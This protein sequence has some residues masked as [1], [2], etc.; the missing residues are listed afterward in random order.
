MRSRNSVKLFFGGIYAKASAQMFFPAG[1]SAV[2]GVGIGGGYEFHLASLLGIF[3][4]LNVDPLFKSEG[5]IVP[6]EVR[7]GV[8]LIF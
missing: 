1:S 8:T 5:T 6:V 4:E 2:F 7:G 3:G